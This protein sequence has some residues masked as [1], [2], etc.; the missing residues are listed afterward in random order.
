MKS[1]KHFSLYRPLSS[2]PF[3][4]CYRSFPHFQYT[5]QRRLCS[6]NDSREESIK[7]SFMSKYQRK[8]QSSTTQTAWTRHQEA[9]EIRKPEKLHQEGFV[10]PEYDTPEEKKYDPN[11]VFGIPRATFRGLVIGI[12]CFIGATLFIILKPD[13]IVCVPHFFLFSGN[14][15]VY[16]PVCAMICVYTV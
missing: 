11:A 3:I 12:S 9:E 6:S 16:N 8:I 4:P 14:F 1:L 10:T 13:A 5:Y 7:A 2:S 15:N